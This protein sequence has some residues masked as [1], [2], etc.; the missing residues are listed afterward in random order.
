MIHILVLEVSESRAQ[1]TKHTRH[2]RHNCFESQ[3]GMYF[4]PR[5]M[6]TWDVQDV[7]KL[8]LIKDPQKLPVAANVTALSGLK[9]VTANDNSDTHS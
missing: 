2:P 6:V 5:S 3:N 4:S 1:S 7:C 9:S 8:K